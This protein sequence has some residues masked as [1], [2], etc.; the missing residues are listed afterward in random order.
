MLFFALGRAPNVNITLVLSVKFGWVI[1]EK[2]ASSNIRGPAIGLFWMGTFY[3][4]TSLN[5]SLPLNPQDQ[6]RIFLL[7]NSPHCA[8]L[9]LL[10]MLNTEQEG[11][12]NCHNIND[13]FTYLKLWQEQ[14]QHTSM[15]LWTKWSELT[16]WFVQGNIYFCR[17]L[18]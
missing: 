3:T 10:K 14:Q 7:W 9:N 1:L 17:W 18:M 2:R 15:W 12:K 8:R 11:V 5:K 4:G 13:A 6:I 16:K